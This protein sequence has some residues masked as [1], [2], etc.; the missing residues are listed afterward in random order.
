MRIITLSEIQNIINRISVETLITNQE[1][2][3][4]A[5][6]QGMST[7]PPVGH[8]EFRDP[9][10]ECH[11]KYGCMSGHDIFVIKV[12]TG[13]YKNAKAGLSSGDGLVLVFSGKAGMIETIIFD[14]G[15]LTNIR[16][17]IAGLITAKYLAPKQIYGIGIFGT[18]HQAKLQLQYLKTDLKTINCRDV[19][20]WGRSLDRLQLYQKEME[21]LGLNIR[22]TTSDEEVVQNCNL[23]ITTTASRQPIFSADLLQAGTHITAVGA[24]GPGKQELDPQIFKRADICVVDSVKQCFEYGDISYAI[25]EQLIPESKPIELGKIISEPTL[26]RGNDEQITVA[27]LTGIAVQDIKMAALVN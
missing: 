12:A 17:A 16:T 21:H 26:G 7:I 8:L 1:S 20:V 2:G 19:W 13:F 27:D 4:V 15:Y 9:P 23:I 6:S 14:Q 11:I 22:L 25:K 3:F 5:Y 10:G 24:D 18:G